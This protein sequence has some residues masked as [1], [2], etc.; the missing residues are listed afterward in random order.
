MLMMMP[1]YFMLAKYHGK[2]KLNAFAHIV[3]EAVVE[4]SNAPHFF[5]KCSHALQ[6]RIDMCIHAYKDIDYTL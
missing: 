1:Q 6:L 2:N 5:T 3:L 4:P